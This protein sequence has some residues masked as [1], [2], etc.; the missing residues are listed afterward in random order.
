M[1]LFVWADHSH[2]QFRDN[3]SLL[4]YLAIRQ[5]LLTVYR[6]DQKARSFQVLTLEGDRAHWQE[7]PEGRT[8]TGPNCKFHH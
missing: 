8:V 6:H 3:L 2:R 4:D 1:Y 5:G 7:V